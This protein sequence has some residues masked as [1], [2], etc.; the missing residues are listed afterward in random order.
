MGVEGAFD[1]C[2]KEAEGRCGGRVPPRFFGK[3]DA[4][5]PADDAAHL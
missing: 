1:L 5:L 3:S 4:V 2:V